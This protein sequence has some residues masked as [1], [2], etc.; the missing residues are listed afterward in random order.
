[1]DQAEFE[2]GYGGVAGYGFVALRGLTSASDARRLF[3]AMDG[4]GGGIVLLDEW[5]AYLKAA[6]VDAGT[7]LG[8]LLAMDEAGGVGKQQALPQ[9]TLTSLIVGGIGLFLPPLHI[10][11]SL[12]RG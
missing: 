12:E 10:L 6:E 1:V 3:A 8:A 11:C 4:N 9:V 5:C 7:G 2:A